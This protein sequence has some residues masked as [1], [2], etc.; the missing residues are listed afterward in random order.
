MR[1]CGL[2][3]LILAGLVVLPG[4]VKSSIAPVKGRVMFDGEPVAN[5][6]ITFS[7]V[8]TNDGDLESG[9]PATGFTDQDGNYIL[10]TFKALDGAL[11]GEHRVTVSLDNS[12]KAKCKREKRLTLE[13]KR[14]D[15]DFEIEMDR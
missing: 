12:N 2:L 6:A 11:V 10:S 3:L 15:N 1:S 9:K 13:V 14:G 5:A 8:P 4:C 7:P